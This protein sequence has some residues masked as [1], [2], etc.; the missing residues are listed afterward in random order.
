MLIIPSSGW[1]ELTKNSTVNLLRHEA[2][3]FPVHMPTP[4]R[5][6][7]VV[8][9]L[10]GYT[11]HP[12]SSCC[13]T[14]WYKGV[15]CSGSKYHLSQI[16]YF[17]HCF[18][19]GLYYFP[20]QSYGIDVESAYHITVAGKVAVK[21]SPPGHYFSATCGAGGRSVIFSDQ[22]H[23]NAIYSQFLFQQA[24]IWSKVHCACVDYDC[25]HSHL[26]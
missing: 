6:S 1:R 3:G 2:G 10:A 17:G 19:P 20:V 25:A 26:P 11:R 15:Y 8:Q 16:R 13:P 22:Y 18:L 4:C 9:N 14:A 23:L 5:N 7:R 21:C 24:E 12:G